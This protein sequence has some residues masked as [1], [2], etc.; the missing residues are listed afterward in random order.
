MSTFPHALV[1]VT[2]NRHGGDISPA[3]DLAAFRARRDAVD[4]AEAN[5]TALHAQLRAEADDFVALVAGG[6]L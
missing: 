5:G 2:P 6:V 3:V 4:A 1:P